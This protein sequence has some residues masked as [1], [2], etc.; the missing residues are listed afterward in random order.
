MRA[1]RKWRERLR[2]ADAWEIFSRDAEVERLKALFRA[3]PGDDPE[4]GARIWRGLRPALRRLGGAPA[5][6]FAS[7]LAAIGPHF[8]T[9]SF[10]GVALAAA[11]FIF[12]GGP[13]P[14]PA[15][16]APEPAL[17]AAMSAVER[18][19]APAGDALEARSGDDLLQFIAYSPANR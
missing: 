8:V 1:W 6:S 18:P 17:V 19:R 10:A 5:P 2:R 13:A 9:A 16:P 7:A 12:R 14:A 4:A 3:A 15:P 11:L